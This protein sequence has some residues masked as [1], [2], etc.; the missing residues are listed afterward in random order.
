MTLKRTVLATMTAA[1]TGLSGL[2]IATVA[3]GAQTAPEITWE[4][5]PEQVTEAA[6]ECGQIDVPMYH[7][8]P[9]GEQIS[10]GFVQVPAE[11]ESRGKLFGNPGGPGGDGYSYFGNQQAFS[12]PQEI[13]NEWDRV[14][15]Q[16]RGLAGSTPVDCSNIPANL[17]P[18]AMYTQ[19]GRVIRESCEAGTPG[20]TASLTTENTAGDWEMVRQALGAEQISI[21]GL[22]YG[23]YLGSVYATQYPEHT[24][25]VV[26]DSAM[27][28]DLAWNGVLDSQEQGYISTLHQFFDWLAENNDTYGMGETPLAAYQAWSAQVVRESGTNPT[29]APPPAQVGD[30]PPALLS[31]GELGAEA[32]TA[33][34]PAAV[35]LQ[36]LVSQL[37]TPGSNQVQSETL[38]VTR[39]LLPMTAQWPYLASLINGSEEMPEVD[40]TE[41]QIEDQLAM[42]SNAQSMQALM[43]CNENQVAANPADI[44]DYIWTNFVTGE[45]FSAPSHLYSSGAACAGADPVTSTPN[46]DGSALEFRPLQINA[47]GDPQTPYA[48]SFRLAEQMNSHFVT[49]NGPG[50]GQVAMGNAA[51][52]Q[53]V[54]EYLRTGTTDVTELPGLV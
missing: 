47:T 52:D 54:V 20:Y 36:G 2:T 48:D 37:M 21:M 5:C 40:L 4:D 46:I 53:L 15:V 22:S 6:A 1:V 43:L 14:A 49:V 39:Q 44:P 26:L 23:T 34:G 12:W 45:I 3:A 51:V 24:D 32:L 25:K 27:N 30:L 28:P 35:Q 31:S 18:V 42:V 7:S 19:Q 50:H 16:P 9:D 13:R 29:V 17:D 11:G 8:D 33:A 38:V 10:V 41:E